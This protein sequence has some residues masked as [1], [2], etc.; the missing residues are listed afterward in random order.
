MMAF[1]ILAVHITILVMCDT[2]RVTGVAG[3]A[4]VRFWAAVYNA[5]KAGQDRV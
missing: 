5:G 1:A 3:W 4:Q 2:G